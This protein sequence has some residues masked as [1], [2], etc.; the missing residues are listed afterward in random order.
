MC[1]SISSLLFKFIA[2]FVTYYIHTSIRSVMK[3][4]WWWV[5]ISKICQYSKEII[6][7]CINK[8]FNQIK[9]RT[10]T[11][12]VNFL[13]KS[14]DIFWYRISSYSFPGNYSFLNLEIVATSNS[15]RN[16]YVHF[17]LHKLIFAAETI[18]GPKLY[19]EIR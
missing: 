16:I 10:L 9:K 1:I 11:F 17:L 2:T 12:K 5:I 4:I 13:W 14:V 6:I 18:Q 8:M 15:C 3:F 7:Y 19:E